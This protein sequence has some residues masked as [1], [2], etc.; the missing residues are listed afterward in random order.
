LVASRVTAGQ[1]QQD[2]TMHCVCLD[3]T[4]AQRRR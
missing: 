4:S 1:Q 3:S 2:T